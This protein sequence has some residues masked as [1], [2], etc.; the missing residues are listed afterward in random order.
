MSA[1]SK[2]SIISHQ[3]ADGH[4]D[5]DAVLAENMA[6][7]DADGK[8]VGQHAM[9]DYLSG[10]TQAGAIASGEYKMSNAFTMLGGLQYQYYDT[11]SKMKI[12][13]LLGSDYLLYYNAPYRVG[14]Y[15]GARYGRTTHHVSAFVEGKYATDR[16]NMFLGTTVFN[17]NYRRHD[18]Q[19]G[20]VSDWAKGWGVSVK[21][22]ALYHLIKAVPR[23]SRSLSLYANA[24]FNS[25]LP[26]AGVYLASSDLSITNDV[27]NEKNILGELGVRTTWDGGGMELSAYL[28]SWRN[29][30]LTVSIAKRANEAAEKYQ[31]RGLNALHKGVELTAHQSIC[32]WLSAKAYAMLASWKW[33]SSGK[34]VTYDSYSGATLKEYAVY[35]N[36]LHVGDAPQTQYGAELKAL[37][38]IGRQGTGNNFYATLSWNANADMYADFEPSSR[39]SESEGDAYKLP[40]YHLFDATVG[41]NGVVSKS[42][43]MNV[44]ATCANIFNAVY[45]QRGIDGKTHDLATFKGYWGAPR[46]LS[47]GARLQF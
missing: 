27:T 11:W 9:I 26:Y 6:K 20:A 41:W 40:S 45:I 47:F 36:N 7:K 16:W 21:G 4:I 29:K 13:D 31:V 35:C 25:R 30:T 5:F 14:D 19:K 32:N 15:I 42:L 18:D 12:L 38:P 3:T 1:D 17:G 44:F 24:A 46:M 8:N 43:R 10:H 34:G 2:N 22:G 37:L 33:K 39:T 23:S 28:A